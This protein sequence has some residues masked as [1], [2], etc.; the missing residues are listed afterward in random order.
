M[1][2]LATILIVIGVGFL[3]VYFWIQQQVA[4][5]SGPGPQNRPARPDRVW[6]TQRDAGTG[7]ES[8]GRPDSQKVAL[9]PAS[10]VAAT[11]PPMQ[12]QSARQTSQNTN[13]IPPK[14]AVPGSPVV[15]DPPETRSLPD[16]L[17]TPPAGQDHLQRIDR[18][19]LR[20]TILELSFQETKQA[21]RTQQ[22][23]AQGVLYLDQSRRIPHLI[24]RQVELPERFF[25]ELRRIGEGA[26]ILEE[27]SFLIRCGNASYTYS[28]GDLDQII[29]QA[30]GV[31]LVPLLTDRAV[32]LFITADAEAI[33]AFIKRHARTREI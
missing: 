21:T 15:A 24:G 18:D 5:N 14:T 27:S 28:I 1:A 33:K 12:S 30:T 22:L 20:D 23:I 31:A 10:S 6:P 19:S 3:V 25:D 29:F 8:E 9:A 26:L 17:P 4:R 2:Y 32:P 11:R 13:Q 16:A 7:Y